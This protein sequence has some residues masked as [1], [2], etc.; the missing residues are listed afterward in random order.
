MSS[1]EASELFVR[2]GSNAVVGVDDIVVGII[3][4]ICG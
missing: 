4:A 3:V 2:E 1:V